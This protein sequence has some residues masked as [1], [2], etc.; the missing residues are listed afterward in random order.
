MLGLV[1][2]GEILLELLEETG[3]LA[4]EWGHK[5]LDMLFGDVFGL[6][7][8]ASQKAS[9][10]TGLF[11][12]LG[13]FGWGCYFAYRKYLQ[14]KAAAPQWRAE[15]DAWWS[16]LHWLHKLAYIAFGLGALAILALFI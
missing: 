15:M 10:W 9:A 6:A 11:L 3:M 2:G 16:S 4:F 14:A 1:L 13:L 7:D 8:E 5:S 12:S